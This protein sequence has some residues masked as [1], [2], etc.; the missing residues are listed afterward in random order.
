MWEVPL[1]LRTCSQV[2]FIFRKDCLSRLI[3]MPVILSSVSIVFMDRRSCRDKG[4]RSSRFNSVSVF[5]VLVA[6]VTLLIALLFVRKPCG[7]FEKAWFSKA[8]RMR[9]YVGGRQSP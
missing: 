3:F 6:C 9:R 2:S 1:F 5:G 8:L 7:K 4:T